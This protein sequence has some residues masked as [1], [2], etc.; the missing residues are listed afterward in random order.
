MGNKLVY[1]NE[2]QPGGGLLSRLRHGTGLLH[3]HKLCG[4]RN[5]EQRSDLFRAFR[6]ARA[7]GFSHDGTCREVDH[8]SSPQVGLLPRQ[9]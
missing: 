4:A 8:D 2:P 7:A 9:L 6:S 5:D 3:V 1:L